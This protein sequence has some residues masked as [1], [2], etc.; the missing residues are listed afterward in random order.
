MNR[1]ELQGVT[2]RYS[3]P[4]GGG[5]AAIQDVSLRI[6]SGE[7]LALIGANGSGKSTLLKLLNG[8]LF[9]TSGLLCHDGRPVAGFSPPHLKAMRVQIGA[10]HQ[11]LA[12][13]PPLLAFENVLLGKLGQWPAWRAVLAKWSPP[14]AELARARQLLESLGIG[15][16]WNAVTR[17]LSGGEQQRVAIARLLYQAPPTML[18]DE[19]TSALDPGL[20]TEAIRRLVAF[21]EEGGRTLV[22][23]LHDVAVARTFFPRLVGLKSGRIAFDLPTERVSDELLEHLYL[24]SQPPA[25]LPTHL[26]VHG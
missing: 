19:P 13:V 16:K 17:S 23:A 11:P 25:A 24:G 10:V 15:A 3:G 8:T 5:P 1:F 14:R 7:R 22:A 26:E 2:R 18:V 12:L 4:T 9:A 21:Q 20:A 6:A